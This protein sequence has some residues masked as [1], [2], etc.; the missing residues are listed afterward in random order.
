MT[1]LHG[2][3]SQSQIFVPPTIRAK[4]YL[5]P[6]LLSDVEMNAWEEQERV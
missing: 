4:T 5:A 1:L 2:P 6:L 3:L